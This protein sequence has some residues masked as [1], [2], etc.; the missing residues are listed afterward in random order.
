MNKKAFAI[1]FLT[2]FI[3]LLGFGLV[4]PILPVFAKEIGAS[5]FEVGLVAA[6]FSLM[7]FFFTPVLGSLSDRIGRR[8]IILMSAALNVVGYIIFAW[9]N[10]LTVLVISRLICGIGAANIGAAQAYISDISSPENRARS[11]GL[12][13]MA[14]G[15][16]FVFGPVFGGLI[17]QFYGLSWV[18]YVAATLCFLNLVSAFFLLPES[19][20]ELKKDLK[21]TI[22]PFKTLESALENKL[23]SRIFL[24][25][26]FN[27]LAFAMMQT[28]VSVLWKEHYGQTDKQIG[29]LFGVIGI[30]SAI[31]QG[32]LV[33][34]LIKK[35]GEQNMMLRGSLILAIG[36][37]SIPLI[38]SDLF[39]V[40]VY[41]TIALISFGSGMLNP[42]IT[43]TL[44]RATNPEEQGAMLGLNQSVG[45]ISR[46]IGPVLS[47]FFYDI[48]YTLPFILSGLVMFFCVFLVYQIVKLLR[49]KATPSV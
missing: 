49:L 24:M 45:S 19:V 33:G 2:V 16:G 21:I 14:F 3:D 40:G 30:C 23:V 34:I 10:S 35:W 42:S 28:M 46:V 44:S 13:G 29:Y 12:I 6:V 32:G 4:V 9:S 8:P 48:H 5:N 41:V 47:G 37:M 39:N 22:F 1:I 25:F 43:A 15:L 18:G 26:L 7:N 17:K 27:V 20:K 36:L 31:T 11:L 38:S